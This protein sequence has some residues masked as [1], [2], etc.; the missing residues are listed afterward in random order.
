MA[1][2]RLFP[3]FRFEPPAT[4]PICKSSHGRL[5]KRFNRPAAEWELFCRHVET[6]GYGREFAATYPSALRAR[7]CAAIEAGENVEISYCRSAPTGVAWIRGLTLDTESPDA[8]SARP[9]PWRAR[10]DADQYRRALKLAVLSDLE[11]NILR[12]HALSP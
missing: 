7:E 3:P 10:S 6:G 8:P 12:H 9:R 1:L 2:R 11:T 4:W 5:H